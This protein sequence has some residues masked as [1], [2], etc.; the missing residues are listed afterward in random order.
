MSHKNYNLNPGQ[1][2]AA[3]AFLQFLFSEDK[4]FIIAGAA[5]V[6]KTHLMTYIIDETMTRYLE[7]CKLLDIAPEYDNVVMTA[8]TNKAAEVLAQVTKRPTQTVHSFFNLTVKDDFES[9]KT[10][11][12]RT[13]RWKVHE[14]KIIFVD[15]CSMIDT[16]L[17][18]V[19]HD[20]TYKC[21]LVYVGD[22]NQ[23]PPVHE[24][25]SPIYK[26]NAP[27]Y[28][29]TQPMRNAGQPALMDVCQQLRETVSTGEFHPIRMVPGVIDHLDDDQM[30]TELAR[31]FHDQTHHARVLAYTNGRVIQY[32]DYIRDL[33]KLPQEPQAGEF[34]VNNAAIKLGTRALAVEAEVEIIRTGQRERI[35]IEKGTLLDIIRIDFTTGL[36]EAFTNV[37]YPVNRHHYAELVKYYARKKNWERMFYL[38]NNFV[39]LRPRDAA[40][41]HKAQGSTYDTVFIDLE[42]ISTCHIQNQ[43]ARM[44]YVAFSR[45]KNRVFLY[46]N[47]AKK[48]GGLIGP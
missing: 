39:D 25:I 9:G 26:G 21:K 45:A 6:G 11:I 48:Y 42:N 13:D 7:M 37:P 41:V 5:G 12:K 38:K 46:G 31:V 47:L 20:G 23:L 17:H 32:N 10:V 28:E 30:Q 44:L 3:D 40:T 36:K 16:E 22:K 24:K 27:L 34:M 29:L 14:R 15:E 2:A 18:K 35:E 1:K 8:T 43:A 19:L 4:E 33:R